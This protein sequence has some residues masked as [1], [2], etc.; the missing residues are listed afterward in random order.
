[1]FT[2]VVE[3]GVI[4]RAVTDNLLEFRS[5]NPRDYTFDKHKTVDDRSYGGGPGMV[6]MYPPVCSAIAR[7]RKAQPGTKVIYLSPQGRRL[8]QAGVEELASRS[9][10]IL[11]SGRYEGI[12]ERVI[13]TEVDE[14]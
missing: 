10:L 2:S 3:H 8:D 1:M 5:W 14:E 12:D 4:G 11:V 9:G 7:A 6:M 13:E